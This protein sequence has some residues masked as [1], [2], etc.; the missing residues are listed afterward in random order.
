MGQKPPIQSSAS[1]DTLADRA[2]AIG[3][4]IPGSRIAS[5]QVSKSAI[6]PGSFFLVRASSNDWIHVGVVKS[7]GPDAFA[8]YEGNT[9]DEGSSNGFEAVERVRG[10]RDKDFIV[11]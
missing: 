3:K 1:C 2:K 11:W 5:G 7:A 9:N 4:F 6:A 10:Y 8:T